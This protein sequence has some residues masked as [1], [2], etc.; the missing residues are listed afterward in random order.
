L[1]SAPRRPGPSLAA[2]NSLNERL[3][4]RFALKENEG[5]HA[6]SFFLSQTVLSCPR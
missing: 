3:Y 6:H 5:V 2:L 1:R 4:R